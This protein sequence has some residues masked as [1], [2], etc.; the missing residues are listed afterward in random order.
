ML[1]F[2]VNKRN[3]SRKTDKPM[4]IDNGAWTLHD[5]GAITLNLDNESVKKQL[6]DQLKELSKIDVKR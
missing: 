5:N 2:L 1:S 4:T 3:Q 6:R